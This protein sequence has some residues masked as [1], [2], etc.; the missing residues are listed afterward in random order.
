MRL[1]VAWLAILILATVAPFASAERKPLRERDLLNYTVDELIEKAFPDIERHAEDPDK[2]K[3]VHIDILRWPHKPQTLV[4]AML[5]ASDEPSSV[6]GR[7]TIHVALLARQGEKLVRQ[8]YGKNSFEGTRWNNR[9]TLDLA[10][11]RISSSETAFGVVLFT[12]YSSTS[13]TLWMSELELYRVKIGRA[14]CRERVWRY[15]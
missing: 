10:P 1:N 11:Y 9:I 2:A 14:S 4:V 3:H 13:Y 12:A 5:D 7:M 8:A 15:V 6:G